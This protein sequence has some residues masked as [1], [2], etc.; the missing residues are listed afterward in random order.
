MLNNVQDLMAVINNGV[1]VLTTDTD[2]RLTTP[3]DVRGGRYIFGAA[4]ITVFRAPTE[5]R[6]PSCAGAAKPATT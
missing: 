4:V 6:I 2:P 5:T 3:G 1:G